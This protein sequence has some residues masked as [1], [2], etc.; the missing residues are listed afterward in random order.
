MKRTSKHGNAKKTGCLHGHTHDSR[1]EAK[2]CNDLHIL[3][4][5]GAIIGLTNQPRYEFRIGGRPVRMGN[6][7]CARVTLDFAYFEMPG[8]KAVAEDVKGRSREADSRDWPLR[9]ALFQA[10]YPDVELRVVR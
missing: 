5:A 9:R 4:R 10:L 7:Q 2:R 6:G 8:E 1:R 3:Q